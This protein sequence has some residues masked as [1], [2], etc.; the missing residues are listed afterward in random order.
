[1]K[2]TNDTMI[3]T[4][5]KRL[6]DASLRKAEWLFDS[7]VDAIRETTNCR[8]CSLWSINE[9]ST[10]GET[11]K[12][13]SLIV[14]KLEES[15][16][17]PTECKDDYAHSLDNCFINYVL[18]KTEPKNLPYYACPTSECE[19]YYRSKE[20]LEELEIEYIITIPIQNLMTGKKIAILKLYFMKDPKIENLELLTTTIRNVVSS[21]FFHNM[22]FNKQ[23]IIEELVENYKE[24]GR[25]KK[26]EDI[27]YPILN[28]IFYRYC[29]YE[30]ASVFMWNHYMN[31]FEL[32]STT[33]I[34][35]TN[36]QPQ[37]RALRY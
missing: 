7:V 23:H 29:K 12:S 2:V 27:F 22:L 21:C 31:Y 9:N 34:K 11:Q 5:N 37:S 25:K 20:S 6:L 36:K 24:K 26:L 15:I 28:S 14:R 10:N 17:Y 35:D 4:L 19:T 8:M 30:A 3:N 16:K 1:M 33:G 18:S 13:T 32:L